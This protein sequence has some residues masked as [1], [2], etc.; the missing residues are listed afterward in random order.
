MR[1]ISM[2]FNAMQ[3]FLAPKPTPAP[4]PFNAGARLHELKEFSLFDSD[5]SSR[6]ASVDAHLTV[7]QLQPESLHPSKSL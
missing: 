1:L 7:K 3:C 2:I 5:V 6:S 4:R